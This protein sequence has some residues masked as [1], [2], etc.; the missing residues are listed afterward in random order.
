MAVVQDTRRDEHRIALADLAQVELALGRPVQARRRLREALAVAH[1]WGTL[2]AYLTWL[3]RMA[4][5]LV[6]SGDVE[7]AVELYALAQRFPLI[8]N[9]QLWEDLAGKHIASA[10]TALPADDVA[11]AQERG[12]ARDLK[13]TVAELLIELDVDQVADS[14]AE[15]DS[16]S[17]YPDPISF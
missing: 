17:A 5:F 14:P 13:A 1:R 10:A 3:P 4:L 12:R 8:G 16:Q 15:R 2:M 9:S 11:K 6:D 7:R